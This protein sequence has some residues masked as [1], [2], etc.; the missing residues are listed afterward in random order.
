MFHAHY[1]QNLYMLSH[2][3]ERPLLTNH[4]YHINYMN[5]I[6][7]LSISPL[8]GTYTSSGWIISLCLGSNSTI[9]PFC[10]LL[11][12]ITFNYNMNIQIII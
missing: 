7:Y 12:K 1:A 8:P 11:H 2:F 3:Y 4:P 6:H 5:P 10:K 9:F